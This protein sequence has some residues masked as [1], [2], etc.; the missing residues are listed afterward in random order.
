MNDLF[1]V[2]VAAAALLCSACAPAVLTE[3]DDGR[4]LK[5]HPGNQFKVQL[6][7][8]PSTGYGWEVAAADPAVIKPGEVSQIAL[9]HPLPGTPV[10]A[11]MNFRVVG[12]GHSA[13]MLV[14][15]QPWMKNAPPAKTFAVDVSVE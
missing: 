12:R 2:A 13:L 10:T 11:V 4:V 3:R 7:A 1:R 9:E 8:N 6:D 15:R 14:Y 5:L